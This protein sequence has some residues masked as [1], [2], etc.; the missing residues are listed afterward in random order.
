MVQYHPRALFLVL[1]IG[2]SLWMPGCLAQDETT[3]AK[4]GTCDAYD[5]KTCEAEESDCQDGHPKCS[6]WSQKGECENNPG[7]M[8]SN[9]KR[10]CLQCPDQANELA[11]QL[12]EKNKPKRKWTKEEY[13]VATDMGV[14][15]NL[16]NDNFKVTEEE[17]SAR[18]IAARQNI[19]NGGF[20]DNLLE[21]C[22]NQQEDC[23]T[24]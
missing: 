2:V 3:S 5:P 7:Y 15:Q 24:W 6:D 9:C 8:L 20:D 14:K 12:A 1:V 23:T 19:K 17:A 10:S 18:I 13:K 16:K 22:K 11:R 21:I 4:E